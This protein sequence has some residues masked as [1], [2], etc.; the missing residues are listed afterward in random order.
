MLEEPL[1]HPLPSS[2][3][4]YE[5][6]LESGC[7]PVSDVLFNIFTRDVPGLAAKLMNMG[8]DRSLL[9]SELTSCVNTLPPPPGKFSGLQSLGTT[10]D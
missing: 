4:D 8:D 3:E 10:V 7:V 1:P 5:I 6:F 2:I 9:V